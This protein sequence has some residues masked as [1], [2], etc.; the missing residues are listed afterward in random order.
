MTFPRVA[1]LACWCALWMIGAP[2]HAE[3]T[4]PSL[5]QSAL[6]VLKER[7]HECHSGAKPKG[8]L[9]LSSLDGIAR[10]N[11]RG[12]VVAPGRLGESL[13]WEVIADERMPPEDPLPESERSIIRR[14][15]EEGAV[16]LKA[17]RSAHWSFQPIKSPALPPAVTGQPLQNGV[18][19]F[20]A[21]RLADKGLGFRQA[22]SRAT[23][24]RRVTFDLTGLPPDPADVE[25]FVRDDSPDA[26]AALVER[27]LESPQYGVRWGKYWLDGA[28]YADSNGYFSADSDRPLAWRYRDYVV[29]SLNRDKPYDVFVREQIAGDEIAGYVRDGDIT[30]EMIEPLVATHF[31]KNAQDGTNES[32]GNPDEVL[33]DQFSVL[34]ENLQIAMNSLLG[35]SIQCARC[36]SHK[37]EPI[38][39]E[40]YH[41]LEAILYPAYLPSRWVKQRDRVLTVGTRQERAE[42]ALQRELSSRQIKALQQSLEQIAAP[43][44]EQLIDSRLHELPAEQRQSILEALRAPA[45][46]R[47]EEQK[48]LLKQHVDPLKISDDDLAAKFPEYA[49]VREKIRAAI[50]TRE[51]ETPPA[52]DVIS[53][54][55]DVEPKPPPHHILLRGQHNAPGPE[56]QPGVLATLST[57]GNGFAVDEQ[58]AKNSS[59]RRLAFARWLT[60]PENPLFA[61]VIVNRV[62]QHHFGTGL[63]PNPDNLGQSGGAPSHPELIDYLASELIRNGWS[64]KSLH[65]LI[66]LSHTW[67]Q[68]SEFDSAAYA[69]DPENRWLWRYPLHRLEA[70]AVRDAMLCVSG[71]LDERR[72]GPY[73]PTKRDAAGVVFVEEG[74]DGSH[75]RSLYLQQRRTQVVT[76]LELFDAPT[77]V[78][79]CT[80]RNTSTVPVQSLALLNSEFV[81]L[82]S[83]AFAQRVWSEAEGNREQLIQ[84]AFRR[85]CSR[86]PTDAELAAAR[87]F[88]TAQEQIY[89]DKADGAQQARTDFCQML[90][91]M[92]AFLYV[93]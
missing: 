16:G 6:T 61:R 33:N 25:R 72:S 83:A 24:I 54:L 43:V 75:R 38:S 58:A 2:V 79:N 57:A 55:T 44:R 12:A 80:L 11:K 4:S 60:S 52:L 27:L 92:N 30:P 65:R 15:I 41:R 84:R 51:K 86:P 69:V 10:G 70:E 36:H 42:R 67:R 8:K 74:R 78:T 1:V 9:D 31:L 53:V 18:D 87:E 62:W 21:A 81:R 59:G 3:E 20:V 85:A 88:L 14:W 26:Y 71:E 5:E 13:L 73:V 76:F 63:V 7:C 56:V 35:L 28:G 22:A 46:K 45:D 40:E 32:D 50:Q 68:S 17:A 82:R 90:L 91:S 39:H 66:L 37:F 77:I 47:N 29:D 48:K 19:R 64:L 89:G 93:E 23:L 49:G 34:E